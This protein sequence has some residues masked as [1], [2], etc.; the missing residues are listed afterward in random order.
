MATI[1]ELAELSNAVYT[2]AKVS[3]WT[4]LQTSDGY[5][6]SSSPAYYGVAYENTQTHEIVIANRGTDFQNVSMGLS[7]LLN[8][9]DLALS[10]DSP[11]ENAAI[12]F[13]RLIAA[14]YPGHT[15]TET[16]HSLGGSEAQ[17][18][19]AAL[20]DATPSVAVTAVTFNAPGVASNY[21]DKALTS[22]PVLNLYAQ[23]DWIHAAGTINGGGHLGSSAVLP[24]GPSF[25]QEWSDLTLQHFNGHL[26]N[27]K[28]SHTILSN[29]VG[30]I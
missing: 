29:S 16:G 9:A 18:A 7:S 20:I 2:G 11:D 30:D 25:A 19:T 3:G 21:F 28:P 17:A 27:R 8:D 14:K 24:E 1:L 26:V 23:G 6:S 4:V 22:Y 10:A 12:A 5:S 15:L 13:A